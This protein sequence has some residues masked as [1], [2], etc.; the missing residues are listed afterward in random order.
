MFCTNN[1]ILSDND[2][3]RLKSENIFH[4]NQDLIEY[5]EQLTDHLGR[6]SKYQLFGHLF[7]GQKIPNLNNRIP[8][9]KGNKDLRFDLASKMDHDSH[10]SFGVLNLPKNYRSA[11]I[12]DGQH[13]LYGYAHS[14]RST[15]SDDNTTLPVLAYENLPPAKEADLFVDINCEQ[16]RVSKNLL[17][18]IYSNLKWDSE[19]YEERIGALRSRIILALDQ[20]KT[21]PIYDRIKTTG[22]KKT[23]HRCLTLTNFNDGLK[24][25][26]LLGE[27]RKSTIIPGPLTDSRTGNS[28]DTLKKAIAMLSGYLSIYAEASPEHWNLGDSPGGYLCTNTA[29]RSLLRVYK[30]ILSYISHKESIDLDMIDPDDLL[31]LIKPY[32]QPIIDYFTVAS[33]ETIKAFR[34]RSGKHG[35]NVNSFH[36][37]TFIHREFNDFLP[38]ELEKYLETV[39]EAGTQEARENIDQIQMKLFTTTIALLKK[40][41]GEEGQKWWYEGVPQKVRTACVN[42]QE[43]EK[44][45]KQ[46]KQYLLLIDYHSIASNDWTLFQEYFSFSKDGGKIKQLNWLVKLN[47]VRN[48]THHPEK[49]PATKD[50]VAYVREIFPKVMHQFDL[51]TES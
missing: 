1:A 50:Q 22:T 11:F 48:I 30:E 15:K 10:T 4:F 46:K 21:S 39:D 25:N 37:M 12:I 51:S 27:I 49:W 24:E 34:N 33:P 38:P 44:G 35:V 5:Y 2:R 41:Y 13:R 3:Q 40:K 32:I 14:E 9:I 17:I 7:A 26:K 42:R 43:A 23:S 8:A 45:I 19:D 16:I 6:A 18:E 36:M 29:I 28:K 20:R 47:D 31:P